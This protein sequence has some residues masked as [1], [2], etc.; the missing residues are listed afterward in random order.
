[1]KDRGPVTKVAKQLG[2]GRSILYRKLQYSN[3]SE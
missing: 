3:T 1:M 2:L